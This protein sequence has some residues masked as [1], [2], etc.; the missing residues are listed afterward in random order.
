A[1]QAVY[2]VTERLAEMAP[3]DGDTWRDRSF[4]AALLDGLAA[5]IAEPSP[6]LAAELGEWQH[7][8]LAGD[9]LTSLF[10]GDVA[11]VVDYL[12]AVDAATI[13]W[14]RVFWLPGLAAAASPALTAQLAATRFGVEPS[15]ITTTSETG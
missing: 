15:A 4:R 2:D 10:A 7:D 13:G 5:T 12:N 3:L 14:E 9:G 11:A 6:V 1:R 8:D